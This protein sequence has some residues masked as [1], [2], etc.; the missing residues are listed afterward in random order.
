M[1]TDMIYLKI[2]VL[3]DFHAMVLSEEL[4]LIL[5]IVMKLNLFWLSLLSFSYFFHHVPYDI[6]L[7]SLIYNR[8]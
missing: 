2:D 6:S 3:G 4:L 7:N 5:I 1:K 8:E